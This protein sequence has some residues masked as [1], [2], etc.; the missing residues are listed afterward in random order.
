MTMMRRYT[1]A[2]MG[3]RGSLVAVGGSADAMVAD[4]AD[5]GGGDSVPVPS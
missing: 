3:G 5:L 1:V 2:A 4:A